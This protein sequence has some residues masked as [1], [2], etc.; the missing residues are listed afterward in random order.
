MEY[1]RSG[2]LTELA[3]INVTNSFPI[4]STKYDGNLIGLL[5]TVCQY[6]LSWF[7]I[8]YVNVFVQ[9]T[10]LNSSISPPVTIE[11]SIPTICRQL[12][13]VHREDQLK[14]CLHVMVLARVRYYHH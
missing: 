6:R 9:S 2:G 3:Q 10:F 4:S 7:L 13:F 1:Y 12:D 5:F 8:Q 11:T 14:L